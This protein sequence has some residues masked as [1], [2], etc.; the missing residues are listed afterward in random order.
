MCAFNCK[1]ARE[2]Y[3]A[4][5]YCLSCGYYRVYVAIVHVNDLYVLYVYIHTYGYHIR[6]YKFLRDVIFADD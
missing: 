3:R 5:M 1:L 2:L 6:M 4:Y